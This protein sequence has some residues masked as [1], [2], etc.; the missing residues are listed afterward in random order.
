[1]CAA[2][3]GET[4]YLYYYIMKVLFVQKMAGVSGSEYYLMNI[5]PALRKRGVDTAFVCVQHPDA[6]EKN[7]SFI[8]HLRDHDVPCH[9]VTSKATLSLSIVRQLHTI[10]KEGNFDILQTN[11]VHADAWGALVKL[12]YRPKAKIVSLKH[13]FGKGGQTSY[14]FDIAPPK[15][16]YYYISRFA[17]RFMDR[18]G[19]ISEGL[20]GRLIKGKLTDPD[21]LEVIHYGFD[22][23]GIQI[24]LEANKKYRYSEN[25][26]VIVGRLIGVKQHHLVIN[27]LP[28]IRK[29]IPDIKLVLVGNGMLE[30][31]LKALVREKDLEDVVIFEGFRRNIHDYIAASDVS[32]LPSSAEGFGIVILEAWHNKVPVIAFDVPAPNEIIRDGVDGL[33]IPPFDGDKLREGIIALLQDKETTRKM[34][35]AA[36]QRLQ[37]TFA[38]DVM[39]DKTVNWY[40][41]ALQ[42][43]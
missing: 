17:N 2:C 33:L 18:A 16:N 42:G 4:S 37:E 31:E 10:L 40:N 26:L 19:A 35:D 38:L 27:E 12:L 30:E 14:R 32:I 15:D 7:A 3:K 28:E 1:M 13:G 6:A 43:A 29:V 36:F 8:K 41:R 22:F 39:L 23:S 34:G 20:A 5:L 11:L 21:K 25:Q 24:D 9:V